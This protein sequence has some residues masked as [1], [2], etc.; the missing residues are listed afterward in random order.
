M[1]WAVKSWTPDAGLFWSQKSEG[2]VSGFGGGNDGVNSLPEGG[3]IGLA[4]L[5]LNSPSLVPGHVL[6][7]LRHVVAMPSGDGDS[8][9]VVADLLDGSERL[10]SGIL[11]ITYY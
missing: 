2:L 7:G 5:A 10:P 1:T 9:R 6:A 11:K 4:F 3:A 8:H